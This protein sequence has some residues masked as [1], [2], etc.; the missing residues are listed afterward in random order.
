M[1]KGLGVFAILA[2]LIFCSQLGGFSSGFSI[3]FLSILTLAFGS[4]GLLCMTAPTDIIE[5]AF[6]KVR[7]P[8]PVSCTKLAE[9]LEG[10]AIQ[11]RQ[12]GLLSLEGKG[13]DLKD[14]LLRYL[15]KRMR[16]GYERNQ[17]L[18]VLRNQA[19][20]RAELIRAAEIYLE[21][22]AS[23]LPTLGLIP[24]LFVLMDYLNQS[25]S[26][27]NSLPT[28][29]IPFG[30]ALFAQMILQ[31]WSGRFFDQLKEEVKLYYVILEEGVSGIQEGQNAEL[32]R[33]KLRARYHPDPKWSD[34]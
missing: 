9:E 31:A 23:L 19:T 27:V 1:I 21:R 7:E 10:L 3:Y 30:M 25:K 22:F 34:T 33:D 14:G 16:D 32:I 18:P 2:Y 13:K 4:V 24:S 8:F 17:L 6:K 5:G 11:V 12:D 20:R 28:V 26:T 29:F 15:L